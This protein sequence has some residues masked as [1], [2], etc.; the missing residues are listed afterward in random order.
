LIFWKNKRASHKEVKRG[1]FKNLPRDHKTG[2][3]KML[4]LIDENAQEKKP[5]RGRPRKSD[6]E[7]K[8]PRTLKLTDDVWSLL[9]TIGGG[10]RANAIEEL[11]EDYFER[12][13]NDLKK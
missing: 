4:G 8:K 13:R 7:R 11:V 1:P 2:D 5:I 6:H 3:K 12:L 9:Q 10:A